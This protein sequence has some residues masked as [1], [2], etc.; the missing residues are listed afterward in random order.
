MGS[1]RETTTTNVSTSGT[2][3]PKPTAEMTALNKLDLEARQQLQPQFIDVQRGGFDLAAN[4]L[5]GQQLPGYLG[6]L[7]GGIS[8]ELTSEMVQQSLR[9][10]TPSF[11]QAGLLDSGVRA[12]V[13][14]RT[15]GDIR[16]QSAEFNIQNLSQLLNLALGGQAQVQQ[17]AISQAGMLGQRLAG[18]TRFSTT[19][20]QTGTS[21][22]KTRENPFLLGAQAAGMFFNPYGGCWVASE[23]FGGWFHPKTIASRF[24]I[25]FMAPNW[26]RKLY[27]RFGFD[28]ARFIRNKP[29]FK[30]IL[31]P[32]FEYFAKCGAGL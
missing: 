1:K 15:A 24:Y 27:L 19:G 26:L 31:K 28:I 32:F 30:R 12:S 4:L 29:L 20:S 13:S 17:P 3:T 16:R 25:N 21:A 7:P 11:Q 6:T 9:D 23:I 5:R 14:A 18:L 10:I 8:P 22:T 2:T